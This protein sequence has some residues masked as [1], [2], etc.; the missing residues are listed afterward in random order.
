MGGSAI[1]RGDTKLMELPDIKNAFDYENNFYLTCNINRISKILAHYELYKS[2]M[3]IPGAIVECGV[4]KG[5]SLIRFAAFRNLQ[6]SPFTKK[7]IGF[8]TFD[9]FPETD[10]ADDMKLRQKFV[11]AAGE[12]SISRQQLMDV[13]KHKGTDEFV[14][15]VEGD[16]TKTVPNYIKKHPE[17][18]ISLLNLDTDIYEPAVTVLEYLY[19]RIVTGGILLI[20]DYG[21]FPGETKAVEEYFKDKNIQISKF[22]FCMTPCYIVKH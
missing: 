13:L 2:V 18:R 4:F 15:L 19:P 14:E 20:D 3:E 6:G 16:I 7:I 9:T 8:D 22:S 21:V 17:L 1:K 11:S 10:Y 12:K 5:A